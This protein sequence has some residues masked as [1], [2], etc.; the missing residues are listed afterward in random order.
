MVELFSVSFTMYA[1]S[2]TLDEEI[3]EHT[4]YKK[5]VNYGAGHTMHTQQKNDIRV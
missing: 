2:H 1:A 5:Y 4:Q 3:S